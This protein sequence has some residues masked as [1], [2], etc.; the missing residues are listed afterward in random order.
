M[1]KANIIFLLFFFTHIQYIG[2]FISCQ[3]NIRYQ[4]YDTRDNR[5][6]NHNTS[7]ICF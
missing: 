4:G 6:F 1:L 5:L 7:K 2:Y 3:V